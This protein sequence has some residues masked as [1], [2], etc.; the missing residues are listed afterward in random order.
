MIIHVLRNSQ[1]K[2]KEKLAI[3]GLKKDKNGYWNDYLESLAEFL[4]DARKKMGK[5]KLSDLF[6]Y[7][8]PKIIAG[9]EEV[10]ERHPH[11]KSK[12][13]TG[14][15]DIAATGKRSPSPTGGRSPKRGK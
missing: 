1:K 3:F 14:S 15:Y 10:M 9:A 8:Y 12:D 6:T 11:R 4:V 5:E 7:D 13:D 2:L